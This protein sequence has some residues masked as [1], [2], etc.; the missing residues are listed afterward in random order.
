MI[1]KLREI[2]EQA[3]PEPWVASKL[4]LGDR[5]EAD[6]F[7]VSSAA[8]GSILRNWG[9]SRSTQE[10][11]ANA[12]LAS[13]AT[14]LLPIAEALENM[15]QYAADLETLFAPNAPQDIKY[16]PNVSREALKKLQEALDE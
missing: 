15:L 8:G 2:V 4:G 7:V 13:L 1:E 14:H 10:E 11:E 6:D 5:H 9:T 12:K 3:S 16:I